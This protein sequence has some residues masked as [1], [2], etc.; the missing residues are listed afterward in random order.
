MNNV[1]EPNWIIVSAVSAILGLIIPYI[2][3]TI[4][5]C[6]YRLK[7]NRFI[8]TWHVYETTLCQG[9]LKFT[10]GLC[11]I[12]NGIIHKYTVVMENDHLKYKGIAEVEDNHLYF[13]LKNSN[14]QNV[15][16]ETCWQ[17][18]DL[19]Y[20]NYECMCG[21]W[22]SNNYDNNTC[23]GVSILSTRELTQEVVQNIIENYY[24][25]RGNS[26]ICTEYR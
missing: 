22:L 2:W 8:G 16:N 3:K 12:K 13:K 15:R 11:T 20:Y 26:L 23:C 1:Q 25:N 5:C 10:K 9:N 17:R 4:L 21:L 18:Y 19:N 14:D 7:K 24:T 6:L